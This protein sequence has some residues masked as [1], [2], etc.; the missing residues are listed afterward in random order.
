MT[1]SFASPP[2]APSAAEEASVLARDGVTRLTLRVGQTFAA[3][4]EARALVHD[5][6]LAQGKRAVEDKRR[7]GGNRFVYV[8]NST[9]PCGFEVR[10]YKSQKPRPAR[11]VI[12]GFCAQHSDGCAGKPAITQRQ[13]LQQLQALAAAG[14]TDALPRSKADVQRV[15][16]AA[17]GTDVPTRMAYRAK[18]AFAGTARQS[19]SREIQKLESLLVQF[20]ALNAA[21]AV[22]V[23][24]ESDASSDATE[25]GGASADDANDAGG[26]AHTSSSSSST[27]RRAF[28]KF[29]FAEHIQRHGC[30][31]VLGL[32]V[33]PM[34]AASVLRDSHVLELVAKDGNCD[35]YVLAVALCDATTARA[36]HR[37]VTPAAATDL[38]AQ[39]SAPPSAVAPAPPRKPVV[40]TEAF[41]WFLRECLASGLALDMPLLCDRTSELVLAA[42]QVLAVGSSL[43]VQCTQHLIDKMASALKAPLPSNVVAC[44]WRAQAAA[45]R[46]E[47]DDELATL[48]L[49]VD[50]K[51][52]ADYLA[53]LDPQTWTKHCVVRKFPLY[54]WQ[55][56]TLGESENPAV[57]AARDGGPIELFQG[58][59]E[60]CM[61]T[62]YARKSDAGQRLASGQ[63]LTM[64]AHDVL[65][66]QR[67]SAVHCCVAPSDG[68]SGAAYVWDSREAF[69]KKRRVNLSAKSCLCAYPD[70]VG[71]PCK[72]LI[73]ALQF[74]NSR[75]STWTLPSLCHPL[76]STRAYFEA[77]GRVSGV[78]MPVNEELELNPNLSVREKGSS[79]RRCS[80]CLG[81]GHNKRKCPSS[82]SHQ[83]A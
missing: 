79:T 66:D 28:V 76:Y 6:A 81:I 71:L 7:S 33:A 3:R 83:D 36:R 49:S 57:L 1:R 69:P 30:A 35:S 74:F 23:R 8:C 75:G 26:R 39:E 25:S 18:D 11:F 42:A 55:T 62:L 13:V 72:H 24:V 17:L 15:L 5:F 14:G 68:D 16:K 53:S 46:A 41:A 12:S 64:F 58:Y 77:Y 47:Y 65:D 54:N 43:L 80:N 56:T 73:A 40:S 2:L 9:T 27:F 60:R 50:G 21:A 4:T 51:A 22:R 78:E 67:Q 63:E 52:V 37:S 59:M 31:R 45:T 20:Q 19:A 44:V 29:P 10:G 70:Q 32:H 38:E 48:S 61:R 82:G 34:G